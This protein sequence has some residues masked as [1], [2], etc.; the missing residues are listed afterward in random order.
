[1]EWGQRLGSY[2]EPLAEEVSTTGY[3]EGAVHR[4]AL[5][6]YERNA[7]A[8]AVCIAFYGCKCIICGFD[9]EARYG[10]AARGLI[11]VHHI[12]PVAQ[13]RRR[14][15]INPV[16]D[17]RPVCANCHAVLHRVEPPYGIDEV[18]AMVQR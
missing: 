10:M 12:T 6:A 14:Y 4:V 9:F 1:V 17:L 11:H 18:V 3:P 13:V 8:R 5:N 7:T 15:L 16:R 2:F